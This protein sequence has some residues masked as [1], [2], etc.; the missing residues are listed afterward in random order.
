[1]SFWYFYESWIATGKNF[2]PFINYIW[3]L[4]NFDVDWNLDLF[5]ITDSSEN[6]ARFYYIYEFS[7]D[8]LGIDYFLLSTL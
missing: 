2:K 4:L 7:K 6:G 8:S 1:M 5:D 3:F